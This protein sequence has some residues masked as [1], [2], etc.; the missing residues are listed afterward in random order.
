MISTFRT[1]VAYLICGALLGVPF[2][3]YGLLGLFRVE[4]AL[5]VLYSLDVAICSMC[6][7]TRFES[8]SGRAWRHR[9]DRRYYYLVKVIDTLARL[10]GDGAN[11][12]E[13]AAKWEQDR[14]KMI[15]K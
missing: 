14:F 4:Y 1:L 3:V 7:N 12:C 5:R 8:I 2:L 10:C 15:F 9:Y 6:H 11:H 13:R